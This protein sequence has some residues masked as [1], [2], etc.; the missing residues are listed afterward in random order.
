[1]WMIPASAFLFSFDL[2]CWLQHVSREGMTR[3]ST[4]GA[5]PLRCCLGLLR[6]TSR[7]KMPRRKNYKFPAVANGFALCS[8]CT[9]RGSQTQNYL[10]SKPDDSTNKTPRMFSS[11]KFN[12]DFVQCLANF[13]VLQ[14]ES[15]RPM[16]HGF[17]KISSQRIESEEIQ[18]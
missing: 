3:R 5:V 14:C 16:S 15:P 2:C 10:K 7:A 8:C 18:Q 12:V 9:T 13:G 1:M 6:N 4:L 11:R 17:T